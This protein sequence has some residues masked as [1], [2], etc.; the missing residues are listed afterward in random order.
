MYKW[1]S[2]S[3]ALWH[4][5]PSILFQKLFLKDLLKY[6]SECLPSNTQQTLNV[7]STLKYVEITSRRRSTWYPR[8]FNVDLSPL[9]QRWNSTLK[10]RWFCV[11]SK[12][13][14]VLISW[15]LKNYKLYINVEKITVFQR[16]NNVILSTLNQRWNLALKQRWFWVDTENRFI[17]MS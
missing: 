2:K 9:I 17:L 10:Q 7:D 12:R 4:V 13:N 6:I 15:Y 5:E 11:D 3:A 1:E 14:F 16:Q 8:W